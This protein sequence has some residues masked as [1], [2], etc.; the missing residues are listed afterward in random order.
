MFILINLIKIHNSATYIPNHKIEWNRIS[1]FRFPTKVWKKLTILK[2]PKTFILHHNNVKN[3]LTN[4]QKIAK[5][6]QKTLFFS[7]V[8]YSFIFLQSS[9]R[10]SLYWVSH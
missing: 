9:L 3:L 5:N 10:I 1:V 7:F 8:M 6:N 4:W 2:M